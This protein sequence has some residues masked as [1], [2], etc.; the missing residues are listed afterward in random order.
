[1]HG[2]YNI[3]DRDAFRLDRLLPLADAQ[4]RSE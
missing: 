2:G 4:A 3:A 1:M